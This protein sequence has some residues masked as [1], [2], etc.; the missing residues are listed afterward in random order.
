MTKHGNILS[1]M[2]LIACSMLVSVH[3]F[4]QPDLQHCAIIEDDTTRLGCYDKLVLPTVELIDRETATPVLET[5]EELVNIA[6]TISTALHS[7][8]KGWAITFENG[9]SWKQIGTASFVVKAGDT[10][11]ISPGPMNSY[12]LQCANRAR[13]I[14]VQRTE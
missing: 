5:A 14:Q 9:L 1:Y 13:S 10:C 7:P 2:L 11:T 8:S 12:L 6:A 4:A 3:A